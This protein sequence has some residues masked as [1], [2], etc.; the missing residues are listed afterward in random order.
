MAQEN[1]RY[2]LLIL[3]SGPGGY[4]AAIRAAQL[5]M[6]VGVVE[7]D[8]LGGVCLNWGCIPTKALLKSAEVFHQIQHAK[9]Y[10]LSATEPTVDFHAVITRS[11]KVAN[12]MSAGVNYLFKTNNINVIKGTGRLV[13]PDRIE[14]TGGSD[15]QQVSA[16]NIIIATGARARPIPGINFDGE[17]IIDAHA[18]MSLAQQPKH[19]VIIGAGAIGVEFAYFYHSIGTKVTL[20]EMMPQILPIE[21]R[22]VAD[23]LAKRY[24]KLGMDVLVNA[25]VSKVETAS[26]GVKVHAEVDKEQRI[27]EGDLALVAI[28]VQGNIEDI[29]LED[30]GVETERGW[31]TVDKTTYQ[32]SVPGIFAIGDVI[33]PPW[34]AHVASAEA[35]NC[36]EMIAGLSP[37]PVDYNLVPGCT[38]CQP[39]VAS[40]GYTREKAEEAGFKVRVGQYPFIASGK[41]QAVGESE[42]FVKL[43]FDGD[44]GKLLGAHILGADATEMI[45]ELVL[46]GRLGI[47]HRE[48]M[49]TT[50]AHP[51][52]TESIAEAAAAALN[53]AIHL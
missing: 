49:R 39:Q 44:S 40:F 13:A 33:G 9:D 4:V 7:R 31:T 22:E 45:A 38:Y 53:E 29:G 28:G 18:A 25:M 6:K 26:K 12:R 10:G 30:V 34:L 46:A 3:G 43:V 42:G 17:R 5:G 11:R 35:I 27:I 23:T 51:T 47:T 1:T 48:I 50:H 8:K 32:T 19:L 2:D 41:A 21:D 16:K 15:S 37:K 20:L 52:L 14:V 36:V 24:R